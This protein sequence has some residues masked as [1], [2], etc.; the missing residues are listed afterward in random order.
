MR[1][2]T[3]KWVLCLLMAIMTMQGVSLANDGFGGLS[4][5]GLEFGQSKN[6][7]M[8]E[9]DLFISPDKIKVEYVF[10][11]SGPDETGEVIFPVPPISLQAITDSPFSL[12]PEQLVSDNPQG[13][14]ASVD[15][16]AIEIKTEK[17]AILEPPYDYQSVDRLR[18]Q[19]DAPG[20][21]VTD[22][23]QKHGI[24]LSLDLDA[25]T[26][27]LKKLS[28]KDTEQLK[29]QGIL[30]EYGPKWSI[31]L[32]YH[33]NQKFPSGEK[34][35][36]SHSYNPAST[37]GIF[38]WPRD[39][40]LSSYEERLIKDYCIDDYTRKGIIKLLNPP[41][42]KN[43]YGAGMAINLDYFLTTANTWKG[44]IGTFRLT[45]DKG[46]PKSILSVCMDG[47]K[48]TAPT[49]FKVE[50]KNFVPSEDLRLLFVQSPGEM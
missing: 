40:K 13:F 35:T 4:S 30:D 43:T 31:R 9:E 26:S 28:P 10:L 29:S 44:P 12:S 38:V 14:T 46:N 36:I 3:G 19:F 20:M 47:L 16:M 32:R 25:V 18:L 17:T 39:G 1:R 41:G 50:R 2:L 15:G 24:P 21:D 23:L 6:V 22:V 45:I 37:G 42:G 8:L 48:K 27:A 11:N 7:Q 33:W 5:S 34:L 49:I